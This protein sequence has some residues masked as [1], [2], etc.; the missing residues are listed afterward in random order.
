MDIVKKENNLSGI[1][2]LKITFYI[3]KHTWKRIV[4]YVGDVVKL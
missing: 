3:L 1:L 2:I 4:F